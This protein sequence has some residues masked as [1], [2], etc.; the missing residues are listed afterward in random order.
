MI[1]N[2][3]YILQY[4]DKEEQT[5]IIE[6]MQNEFIKKHCPPQDWTYGGDNIVLCVYTRYMKHEYEPKAVF[7]TIGD[8]INY[9]N[10]NAHNLDT[11]YNPKIS[12]LNVNNEDF[13]IF[14]KLWFQTEE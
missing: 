13:S 6:E 9:I 12:I 7:L 14:Q 8:A 3:K 11:L 5:Q 4:V 10:N 2:V 1:N